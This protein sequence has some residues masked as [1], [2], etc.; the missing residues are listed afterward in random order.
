[1][2]NTSLSI[3]VPFYNEEVALEENLVTLF[4]TLKSSGLRFEL[5]LANDGSSD[6]SLKIA[7]S[8]Q[9]R[10]PSLIKLLSNDVNRGRGYVLKQAF[11]VASMD[12]LGYIDADLEIPEHH[13]LELLEAMLS[14][15]ADVGVG[16]KT[17]PSASKVR[18]FHRMLATKILNGLLGFCLNSKFSDHQCGLKIFKKEALLSLLNKTNEDRWAFDTELLLLAQ[19]DNFASVEIGVSLRRKRKSTVSVLK[20]GFMFLRKIVSFWKR[21]LRIQRPS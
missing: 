16:D 15:G 5:I 3:V 6:Q 4:E 2:L 9:A 18:D 19:R 11:L 10:H 1:M 8:F 12:H 20:T 13:I 17:K 21:G 7:S 14:S